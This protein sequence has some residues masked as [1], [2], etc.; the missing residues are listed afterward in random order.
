MVRAGLWSAPPDPSLDGG[1]PLTAQLAGGWGLVMPGRE[2]R[3][4]FAA[5]G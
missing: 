4:G 3:S 1:L 2:T 5:V